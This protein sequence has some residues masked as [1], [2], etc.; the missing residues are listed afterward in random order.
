MN[1]SRRNTAVTARGLLLAFWLAAAPTAATLLLCSFFGQIRIHPGPGLRFWTWSLWTNPVWQARLTRLAAAAIVGAGMSAGGAAT[2]ALLRNPL[3]DPYILGIASGA[4]V[5]VRLAV[6][7]SVLHLLPLPGSA[8]L[9]TPP[10]AFAGALATCLLVYGLAQRRGHLDAYSLILAG[11]IVNTFNYSLMLLLSMFADPFHVDDFSR[12]AMG[13]IPDAADAAL[14]A[15]CGLCVAAGWLRL[16]LRGAAFNV[17]ALGADIAQ[18][19]GVSVGRLRLETFL[20]VGLMAAAAV[21]LAGPVGFIGLIVP[22]LCRMALGPDNRRLA[23][24]SGFGGACVLMAADTLCRTVGPAVGIGKIPVGVVMALAGAPFFIWL[25]RR[26][27][28]AGDTA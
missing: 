20:L 27:Y 15:A 9:G 22:H 17:L 8:L 19:S 18:S 13:E 11:V 24:A 6:S 25:M 4:G 5:G 3:A 16:F 23:L 21:A 2:Q 14:L 26:R 1:P 12:W 7:L 10:A 28:G